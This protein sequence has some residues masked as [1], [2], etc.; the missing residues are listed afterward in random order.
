MTSARIP[1]VAARKSGSLLD[2]VDEL[3][4]AGAHGARHDAALQAEP[5]E[6]LRIAVLGDEPE[7]V[8]LLD[9]GA[10]EQLTLDAG[11]ERGEARVD[12]MAA[13]PSSAQGTLGCFAGTA[14]LVGIEAARRL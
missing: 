4:L 9:V 7:A 14:K 3:R 13:P 2:V 11:N 12:G 8:V 5:V 1:S 6:H 10:R